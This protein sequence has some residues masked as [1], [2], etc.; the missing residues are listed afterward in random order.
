M[1]TSRASSAVRVEVGTPVIF[2]PSVFTRSP[3]HCTSQ[4]AVDPVP[5]PTFM[6]LSTNC[7]ARSAAAY[8]AA[9][10]G[11]RV[12]DMGRLRALGSQGL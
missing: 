9:S 8:L 5:S 1:P 10:M 12:S 7:D 11:E 6:P 3:R 4:A 2:S